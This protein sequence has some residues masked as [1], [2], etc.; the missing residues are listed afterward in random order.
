MGS[1][2]L[3]T[4]T[5][6]ALVSDNCAEIAGRLASSGVESWLVTYYARGGLF[7]GDLDNATSEAAVEK[8]RVELTRTFS[9]M[10]QISA[11]IKG[12]MVRLFFQLFFFPFPPIKILFTIFSQLKNYRKC[13]KHRALVLANKAKE[14]QAAKRN[15]PSK[16]VS[17]LK[18]R[19]LDGDGPVNA[20]GKK[21][22]SYL[23]LILC[24]FLWLTS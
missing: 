16:L 7:V 9:D 21:F 17:G 15:D 23:I 1:A 20:D 2:G 5:T 24:K 10:I 18:N 19:I 13:S 4:E 14:D 22:K 11:S 3:S 8:V 12:R 6:K